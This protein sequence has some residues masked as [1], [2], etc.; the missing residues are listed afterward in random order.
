MGILGPVEKA[1]YA[2]SQNK[3]AERRRKKQRHS[4]DV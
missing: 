4:V 3:T 1:Q 2:N